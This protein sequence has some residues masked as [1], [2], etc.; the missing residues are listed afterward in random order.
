V[1]AQEVFE[2]IGK[3]IPL[4]LDGGKTPGGV[5]STVVDCTKDEIEILR[6]GPISQAELDG[7][8]GNV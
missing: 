2:Q 6:E 3:H 7:A 4:I 1:T 5:S 8:L